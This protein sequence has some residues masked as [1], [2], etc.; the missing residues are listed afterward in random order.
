MTRFF[1]IQ[2]PC[3][4]KPCWMEDG[5]THWLNFA[6][7]YTPK[8]DGDK[9]HKIMDAE[10]IEDLDWS[11]SYLTSNRTDCGWLSPDGKWHGC[12]AHN[13]DKY[14]RLVLHLKIR[15]LECMG[16]VRVWSRRKDDW[17]CEKCPTEAQRCWLI[18]HGFEFIEDE[19]GR[20]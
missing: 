11:V 15:T 9:I 10:D 19:W 5:G 18:D 8:S 16:W 2:I 17:T 14:A 1:L 13:H 3:W 12:D 6:G 20:L 4:K 7:G